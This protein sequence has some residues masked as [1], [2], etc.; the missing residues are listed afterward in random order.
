MVLAALFFYLFFSVSTRPV[1]FPGIRVPNN[2]RSITGMQ[3][4]SGDRDGYYRPHHGHSTVYEV[5]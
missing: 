4:R 5:I 1:Y 2:H 3:I